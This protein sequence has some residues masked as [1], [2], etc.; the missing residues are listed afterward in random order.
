MARSKQTLHASLAL[1]FAL[2]LTGCT[3][4]GGTSIADAVFGLETGGAKRFQEGT[5]PAPEVR[6]GDRVIGLSANTPGQCIW[7]R[8]GSNRRLEAA[9]PEGFGL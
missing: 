4:R 1:V 9:C 5:I 7:Q 2:G 6:E 8:A 3:D